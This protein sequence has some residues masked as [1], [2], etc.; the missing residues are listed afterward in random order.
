MEDVINLDGDLAA[1]NILSLQECA[2]ELP[3]RTTVTTVLGNRDQDAAAELTKRHE[4]NSRYLAQSIE[5]LRRTVRSHAAALRQA[6]QDLTATDEMSAD[7][8]A[9]A[10]SLIDD[11]AASPAPASPFAGSSVKGRTAS[12][13]SGE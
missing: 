1:H 3:P 7:A 10:T 8:A 2:A 13:F 11:I 6:V 9:Q 5:G 12:A 4:Q